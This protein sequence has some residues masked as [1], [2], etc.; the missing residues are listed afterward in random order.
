VV[1]D[2]GF[3]ESVEWDGGRLL[4]AEYPCCNFFGLVAERSDGGLKFAGA[5]GVEVIGNRWIPGS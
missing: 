2:T 3:I 5:G 4:G 1:C